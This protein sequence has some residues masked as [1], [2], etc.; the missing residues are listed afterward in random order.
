MV[1]RSGD[2]D[3]QLDQSLTATQLV[4]LCVEREIEI[5][6]LSNEKQSEVEAGRKQMGTIMGRVFG[7]KI[8][9]KV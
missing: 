6:G 2:E 3:H 9:I 4:N 8:E 5:P 7:A 1:A